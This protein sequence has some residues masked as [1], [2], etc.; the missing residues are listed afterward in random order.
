MKKLLVG[1]FLTGVLAMAAPVG[2]HVIK[3]IKIGGEGGWDYLTIDSAAGRLY[4]SHATKVEVVDVNSGKVIGEIPDTPGVH[5]IAIAPKLGRGFVSNGRGNSVTIFDLKTL[6]TVGHVKTGENPDAI[7]FEP[8][9]GRVFTFNGRSKNA[10][11]F[12]GATGKVDGTIELGGK[13]EFS[14]ADGKG[15]IYANI[16]DTSEIVEVD[17]QKLSVTKRYFLKPCESP[18]GLAMD[19]AK[20]RLFSACDNK[21]MAISDPD[22][23]SV[24]G[25]APIGEGPD[26]AGFDAGRG[27]A[28]TSN[29]GDG[30]ITVVRNT[31]GFPA[32]ETVK[33]E[34][35]ARTLAVDQKTHH[36]YLSVAQRGAAP[37]PAAATP[38]PRPA[39]VPGTFKILVVGE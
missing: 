20:R 28:F 35:G 33:T 7:Q 2:Y 39:I 37:Q 6:K 26:G 18:S 30:T 14:A 21:L 19:T 31:S 16:E 9:S 36:L 24:I 13:P 3:E 8:V 5:G 32:A 29:G 10:T 27:L 17:A 11:A 25:T 38:R 34:P 12:D 4:V 23:G 1:L 22:K 15:K